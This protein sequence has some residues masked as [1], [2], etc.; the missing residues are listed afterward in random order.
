MADDPLWGSNSFRFLFPTITTIK[1]K[2][3]PF[4]FKGADY[5]VNPPQLVRDKRLERRLHKSFSV[6]YE[7][8]ALGDDCVN[9]SQLTTLQVLLRKNGKI[10][11]LKGFYIF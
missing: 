10:F 3:Y 8:G 7:T 1:S 11:E 4:L 5:C 6:E 2:V 9:P